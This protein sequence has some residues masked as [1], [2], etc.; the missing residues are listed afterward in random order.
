MARA[1][2]KDTSSKTL[3][4]CI[5][6]VPEAFLLR[7]KFRFIMLVVFCLTTVSTVAT[8]FPTR[9]ASSAA[10]VARFLK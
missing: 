4:Y 7:K 5:F 1:E 6:V 8:P 10:T 2:Q 9:V 3:V